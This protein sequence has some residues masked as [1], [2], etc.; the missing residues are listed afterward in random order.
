MQDEFADSSRGPALINRIKDDPA[1]RGCEVRVMAH[2]RGAEPRRRQARQPRRRRGRGR[3]SAEAGARSEGHP[4]RAAHPHQGR[5]R[6]RGR[7]QPGGAGRS[8]AG[9]RAGGLADRAEAESARP[10]G[11]GRRQAVKCAGAVAWAA[12]EMPKG[13]PTRYRAGIDW[14]ITRRSARSVDDVSPKKTARKTSNVSAY[15]SSSHVRD[16][17]VVADDRLVAIRA[18]RDQSDRHAAHLFQPRDVALR[19]GRQ[20]RRSRVA[21]LVGAVQPGTIS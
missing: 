18:G 16:D 13:M 21:P 20:L 5:R 14:G 6:S 1:L 4:P 19:F 3:R 12:F 9:R 15:A 10:R 2:E 7:R 11:A 17:P 8:V